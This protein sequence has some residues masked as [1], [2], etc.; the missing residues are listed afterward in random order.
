MNIK[1]TSEGYTLTELLVTV[2][3]V[4]ILSG[5]SVVTFAKNWRDERV[6]AATRETAAW[7]E[8]ARTIAVQSSTPCRVTINQ[9][10]AVLSI[11][12]NTDANDSN[13]YCS[14]DKLQPLRL[15]SSIQGGV[16]LEICTAQMS[17]SDPA[18]YALPC[19]GEQSGS[20]ILRF[21]P[22]GTAIDGTLIKLHLQQANTDR[23]IAVMSPLGQIR[24]GRATTSGCDFTTAF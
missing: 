7:L 8:Q 23:C 11:D 4:G 6:K 5:I 10:T 24:S 20:S 22:R 21:T 12:P 1:N 17:M 3:I 15:R 14:A 13:T 19:T 2:A 16:D 18:S 9:E